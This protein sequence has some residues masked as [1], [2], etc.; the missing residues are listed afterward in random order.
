MEILI[1]SSLRAE[2]AGSDRHDAEIEFSGGGSWNAE[3]TADSCRVYSVFASIPGTT[4]VSLSKLTA[5]R[6]IILANFYDLTRAP[7]LVRKRNSEQ[8]KR[9][10]RSMA[11]NYLSRFHPGI[12]ESLRVRRSVSRL[13]RFLPRPK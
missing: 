6:G 3:K 12:R 5:R 10:A 9:M 1:P 13:I 11:E 4:R 2:T 7:C 8:R